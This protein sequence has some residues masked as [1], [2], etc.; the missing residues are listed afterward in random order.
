MWRVVC[1]C[2]C[3]LKRKKVKDMECTAQTFLLWRGKQEMT[4]TPVELHN[5]NFLS[6]HSCSLL[7]STCIQSKNTA[8]EMIVSQC[9]SLCV[10]ERETS[11]TQFTE[12][13]THTFDTLHI[14]TH[15]QRLINRP[16]MPFMTTCFLVSS[17]QVRR[18]PTYQIS[19]S[20]YTWV[21]FLLLNDRVSFAQQPERST[22]CLHD[23]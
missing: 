11:E 22:I 6:C 5:T 13:H 14:H 10:C 21:Q 23:I 20:C 7:P 9:V 12:W 19:F 4:W 8:F 3:S 17:Y 16:C 15:T 18:K 2:V 1:L